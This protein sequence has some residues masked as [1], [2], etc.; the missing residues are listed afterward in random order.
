M[1]YYL[2]LGGNEGD[3]DTTMATALR[4]LSEG[5]GEVV[6]VSRVFESEAW[7]YT[8]ANAYHNVAAIVVTPVGPFAFL[9]FLKHV[10]RRLG[11]TSK[12]QDG[13]YHDRPIDIDIL[14]CDNETIRTEVLE[15]PH[16]R[17]A[18]RRFA[19]A[20]LAEIAPDLWHPVL[21]KSI[22]ELLSECEDTGIVTPT[23]HLRQ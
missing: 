5:D 9:N 8:S 21:K 16:P 15:I 6:A 23:N 17:L 13:E 10:E 2:L 19:L 7:G 20:P 12:T 1:R 18:M 11:R 14:L 22:S 3:V 4:M